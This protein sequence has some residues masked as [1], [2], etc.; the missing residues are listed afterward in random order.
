MLNV[1]AKANE[2]IT[3]FLKDRKDPSCIRLYLSQGG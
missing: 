3:G 2:Q 1:T